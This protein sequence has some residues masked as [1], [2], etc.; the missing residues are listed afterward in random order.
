[1][2]GDRGGAADTGGGDRFTAPEPVER[3]ALRTRVLERLSGQSMRVGVITAPAGYGKTSHASAWV[4]QDGRP[5]AWI[6]LEAAHDDPLVLLTDLV[7]ALSAVTDFDAEGLA[8]GGATADQ[9]A[10]RISAML[11]RALRS[12]TAP[13]VL[14]LDDLHRLQN[15]SA[16]DLLGTLASNVPSGSALLL[17]GRASR[18]G[19]LSTL[20]VGSTL[21]EV[22]VDDLALDADG[23]AAV[24]ASM[25]VDST[26]ERAAEVAEETE[27]WPVGVRLA[28]LATLADGQAGDRAPSGLRG[29]D[30]AVADYLDAEWLWGLSDDE[31]ELLTTV[32]PLD[33]LSG[34][35]C[36]AVSGRTDSGEVLHHI[37]RNRLLLVPLDRR[38]QV[39]RMHG[40]LRDALEAELERS[41]PEQVRLVH[42]QASAWFETTG[43][44][45]RAVRHAVVAGDFDRAEHLVVQHTPWL[46]TNGNYSTIGRWVESLP[47]DRVLRS[48][49]LCLSAALT[50]LGLGHQEELSVWLRVGEHA[51]ES[52]P[53][54]D[55]L[56]R[57]CLLDLRSTTTVGPAR[58]A[59]EAAE[60]AYQGLPPGIWH[61]ASCL[62]YAGWSW[63][64]GD[65]GAAEVLGEGIEEA[66]VYGAIAIEAHS[67][68]LL[69]MIAYAERDLARG[70]SVAD[71]ALRVAAD[72][73]LERAPGMAMV[74][75]V[76]ALGSATAGDPDAARAS[77]Q[78]ARAQLALIEVV[79]GWANVQTRI[80][81][82]HVSLLLGDRIGAETMLR[83]MQ[84]YLIRLPD[85]I[86]ARHQVAE[87][88]DLAQNLRRSSGTGSSA[89][90]TAELRVLH[91]LPTNLRLAEIGTRLYV[92][93][94][95]V[96]THCSSIYRKLDVGS[97]SE[98]VDAARHLGLLDVGEPIGI[99]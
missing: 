12:C 34:P 89:L 59:L 95:T 31:R 9:Y 54:A 44:I 84:A 1:M 91:Y 6:D 88:E 13:F 93:R 75:A 15:V 5:V 98:A 27:G 62:A 47:R 79:S 19:I 67:C 32:S 3:L 24:L 78:L 76:Q 82:A 43:D 36:N 94:Y 4:A 97:R 96:K 23:V 16:I 40:L 71:R 66:A 48:P 50:A 53:E 37:F 73:G 65:E 46:Y 35:L 83:E 92:S 58:P 45:D 2:T 18:L 77:W 51:V 57:L 81:L 38:A 90:T 60:A 20:R 64:A 7:A 49:S 63:T 52:S 87:L 33:W 22:G 39:Y 11:G 99:P 17:V 86:G 80:A 61:A 10:T 26:E 29:R 55:P 14:V 85:A 69:A 56:V 28:G 25:G 68:G 41:D 72:H 21:V 74:S 30:R 8:A 70:R 42:Q